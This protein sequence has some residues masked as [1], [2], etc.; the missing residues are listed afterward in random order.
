MPEDAASAATAGTSDTHPQTP[1]RP[2]TDTPTRTTGR[3]TARKV[4]EAATT[5]ATAPPLSGRPDHDVLIL[6]AGFAGAALGAILARNGARVLIVDAGSHPKFAVGE[7]MIPY[8]L[9]ALRTI[10]ERYDVPEIATLSS[11]DSC[12]KNIG[13]VFGWKKHFG[14]M[15]HTPGEE[16]DPYESNQFS[17]PGLLN[18]TGHLFRQDTDAY[19][20]NAAVRYGCDQRLNFRV[21]D[22]DI[23]DD[24]VSVTGADGTILRARYLVDASGFRS[25]LAE[26]LGLREEPTRFKH[27]SRSIFTH[28]VDAVTADEALRHKKA[29]RP[30]LPWKD[31]TM[32][33]MFDR[34]WFWVIPF[35][36]NPHSTNPLVSVGVTLDPR[37][38]PKDRTLSAEE[39]FFELAARFPAVERN[40]AGARAVRPWVSTE[41][42]QYSSSHSVGPRW[43]LMSHAA[44]FL[45]PLF[46]RGLSNT[47]EVINALSWR[48]LEALKLDDFSQER[49]AYVEQLEQGLLDY[50]DNLVNCAYIAFDHYRLWNAVFRIWGFGSV[51]GALRLQRAMADYRRTGDDACF[52]ELENAPHTG[53][54]WPDHDDY[55]KL[56]DFTVSQV[57]AFEQGRISADKAAD[58]VWWQLQEAPYI[59]QGVGFAD[60]R[61]PFIHP[62][63]AKLARTARWTV[64]EAPPDIRELLTGTVKG[65][66]KAGIRGRR[67]F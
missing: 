32:H 18:K 42:L 41:R 25:P 57:E 37:K 12:T 1:Q 22:V 5:A 31:G 34:G 56:F 49:F 11:F 55:A 61:Q 7:S 33:H 64:R 15:R 58:E 51:I 43:C 63:P 27:H 9:L 21:T 4:A 10:A 39:E 35:N 29:D 60:P 19:L 13:P 40:F 54:W 66:A 16:P 67:L 65:V 26:K 6:G 44:G 3:K 50:N 47:A 48:L 17:T 52:R 45:D 38:Y 62:T 14:F 59:P 53:L 30:P 28:V 36:N 46:S 23:H 24:A 8:T 20:F 2:D